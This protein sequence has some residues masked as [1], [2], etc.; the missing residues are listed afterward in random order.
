VKALRAIDGLHPPAQF[1]D[2]PRQERTKVS[3]S[4]VL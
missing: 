4:Q 3:L 1:F 2:Q